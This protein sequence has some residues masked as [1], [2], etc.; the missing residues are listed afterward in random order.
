LAPV[1]LTEYLIARSVPHWRRRWRLID[2]PQFFSNLKIRLAGTVREI[3]FDVAGNYI[4]YANALSYKICLMKRVVIGLLGT[5]LDYRK[6]LD[7][8][9]HWRPSVSLCQHEELLIHRFELL[10]PQ[11]YRPLAETIKE[12][13]QSVSPETAVTLHLADIQQPWDFEEVYGVLHDFARAYAFKPDKEEYLVH[14]TTGTHVAQIC[15]FLLTE[16]RYIPGRLIQTGPPKRE[17]GN[18][19]GT[20]DIID[21]DLSRYDRIAVRAKQ[22][23]RND[24]SY[25]KSGIETRNESFNKLIVEIE[26]VAMHSREPILLIGP[27]GAG[28]SHL[29]RRIYELKK[30]RSQLTGSFVEVNCAT[31]RGDQALST[32]FGHIKGAFTGASQDRQGLIREAN[33]GMI[34]LD[35]IGELGLDEQAMLL[36][37]IE[38]KL[39][40]PMGSDKEVSSDFQLI[41]GTNRDLLKTAQEGKFRQDLLERIN[42]W[43]FYF[44]GLRERR[45]DIRPN[46]QYELDQFA[47]KHGTVVR[48][49]KEAQADFLDFALSDEAKWTANFRDLNNAIVRMATLAPGGRITREVVEE[50]L[51]RLRRKWHKGKDRDSEDRVERLLGS[52]KCAQLDLFDRLQ[53]EQ[54]LKVCEYARS[55][56]DAGRSLFSISRGNRKTVND[57]DRLKKYLARFGLEWSTIR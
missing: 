15:L 26:N 4:Y 8:W 6:P 23:F 44:P 54:V 41:C 37:A 49:N 42:L 7:R 1:L 13:I 48:F 12:D 17:G 55:I 27:T 31:I 25:L 9:N 36:R 19:P 5:N 29:A 50:E 53:L 14:I 35:E 52:E 21:L 2:N 57:A 34:F 56:S 10:Y 30:S 3:D 24:L 16:A 22:D 51:A 43:T 39:F 20:Y 38:E 32:L 11:K 47:R 45:E 18:R 46:I 33:K 28:K 40:F